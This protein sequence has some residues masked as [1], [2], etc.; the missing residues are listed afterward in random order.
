MRVLRQP[1]EEPVPSEAEVKTAGMAEAKD[2]QQPVVK[3]EPE[4]DVTPVAS[5][6]AQPLAEAA[7]DWFAE[8]KSEAAAG[9]ETTE[10][11]K[12]APTVEKMPETQID[13]AI[14]TGYDTA[15][16]NN[17]KDHL[18]RWKLT[19]AYAAIGN[20]EAAVAHCQKLLEADEMVP[21]VAEYLKSAV[22]SGVQTRQAYQLL[23]DACFKGGHLEEALDAY[24]KALSLLY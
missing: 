20:H 11:D 14:I 22:N 24:R 18:T 1:Q 7:P 4:P 12:P 5:T 8:L 10:V 16:Q 19:Q 21:Q 2:V 17:P 9:E 23:G 15:V 6:A 13:Q 3:S